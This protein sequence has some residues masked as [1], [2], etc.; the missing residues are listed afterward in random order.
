MKSAQGRISNVC[1]NAPIGKF[2]NEIVDC[3]SNDRGNR[4]HDYRPDS[5]TRTQVRFI[6]IARAYFCAKTDPEYLTYVELPE[7]E[8]CGVMCGKLLG[9]MYGTRAGA[10]GWHSE[11]ASTLVDDLGFSIGNSSACI[12]HHKQNSLMCSA[13]ADGLSTS[14]ASWADSGRHF[15]HCMG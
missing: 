10:N 6:D 14:R 2:E 3:C 8:G 1:S 11:Y 4:R 7:E 12:F 15:K 9:H 5:P 13:H